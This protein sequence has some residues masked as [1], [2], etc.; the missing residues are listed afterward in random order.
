MRRCTAVDVCGG[1]VPVVAGTG[2]IDTARAIAMGR[3][4]AEL[5]D[6]GEVDVLEARQAAEVTVAAQR[7][8][9]PARVLRQ[10]AA[11]LLDARVAGLARR[12]EGHE[13]H[14]VARRRQARRPRVR[15]R[16]DAVL[17]RHVVRDRARVR[18]QRRVALTE[19]APIISA[20]VRIEQPRDAEYEEALEAP[21]L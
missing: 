9:R 18:A 19:N 6:Q 1:V 15:E 10:L 13:A 5:G 17:L 2:T 11:D 4:A 3:R 7:G 20:S 14:E 12:E 21:Y 16:R 8:D